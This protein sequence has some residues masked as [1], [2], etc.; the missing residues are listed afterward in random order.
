M[1]WILFVNFTISL[2]IGTV[3]ISDKS[4]FLDSVITYSSLSDWKGNNLF[5]SWS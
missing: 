3:F 5:R 1:H 2:G 4:F